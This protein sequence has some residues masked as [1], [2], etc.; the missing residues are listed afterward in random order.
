MNQNHGLDLTKEYQ[1]Q[2]D[3]DHIFGALSLKCLTDLSQAD[4]ETFLP[5]GELQY[6]TEDFMSCASISPL[7]ILEMK[8]TWLLR[9]KKISPHNELWLREKGYIT[10]EERVEFS[11]RFT[12]INSGTTRSGNSFKAPLE[13]IRNH[14]LIPKSMLPASKTMSFDDYHNKSA[15][16]SEM[17]AIGRAFAIR[18][19]INYD[20]VFAAQVPAALQDDAA[21]V[22]V[23]AWPQPQNGIYPKTDLSFNHAVMLFKPQ[24]FAFDNYLDE[25]RE[26]DFIKELAP[27]YRFYDHGYRV[28][29]TKQATE[30]EIR[31][32]VSLLTLLIQ[33]IQSFIARTITPVIGRLGTAYR[34]VCYGTPLSAREALYHKALELLNTDVTPEDVVDDRYACAEVVAKIIWYIRPDIQWSNKDS[35]YYM[36][37]DLDPQRSF[38]K[39]KVPLPGDLILSASGFRTGPSNIENGHVGIYMGEGKIASNTS[40]NG[41]FEINY[42]LDSWRRYYVD[43]GKYLMEFYRLRG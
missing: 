14:G 20:R 7:N 40:A 35:T 17:R 43:H 10:N 31:S 25:N 6:G 16:T 27:N 41:K 42:T 23:H 4:R 39:V 8:F 11:D 12:A 18:F 22:G 28:M 37:R 19:T 3:T 5:R 32:T 36:R 13:S 15:I 2:R 38:E 33:A 34:Y 26:G 1:D 29:V 21:N 9:K 30:D 24:Y